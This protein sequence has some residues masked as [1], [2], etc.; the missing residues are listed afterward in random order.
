MA[1][2]ANGRP[3]NDTFGWGDL[4]TEKALKGPAMFYADD[5][6]ARDRRR[7]QLFN[8]ISGDYGLIVTGADNAGGI[9]RLTGNNAYQ[10]DTRITANSLFVDGSIAGNAT[11]SGTGT[12]AGKGA[13]GGNVNNAGTV[14]TTAEG[15]LTISGDYIQTSNGA[16]SIT[17]SNPL[18]VTGSAALDGTLSVGLP[19]D[20][21]IVQVSETLLHSGLGVSG[22]FAGVDTSLFLTGS[23]TY[24]ANDVTGAFSRVNTVDAVANSGLQGSALLQTAANVESALRVA[25]RWATSDSVSAEQ[26][27]LLAKA[28]AFQQLA[29]ASAAAISL[30]RYPVRRMPPAMPSCSTVLITKINC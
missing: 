15:G 17:L 29:T 30:I 27:G 20:D 4:N 9:L 28:A 22:Q 5:F 11:V 23:V 6:T 25:D 24:G 8:D 3:Y 13:I 21:Y 14:A 2:T 16:L 1:D 7:L 10:G 26:T 12:L 19:G 18:A